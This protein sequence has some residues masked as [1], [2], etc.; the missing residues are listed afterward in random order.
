MPK[1]ELR[2][3]KAEGVAVLDEFFALYV[4][5]E[6]ARPAVQTSALSPPSSSATSP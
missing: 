2:D 3:R 4:I 5:Q 1:C 6:E